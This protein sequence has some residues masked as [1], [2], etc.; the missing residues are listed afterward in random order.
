MAPP[1]ALTRPFNPPPPTPPPP[2][3]PSLLLLLASSWPNLPAISPHLLLFLK[4]KRTSG[5]FGAP[6][7]TVGDENLIERGRENGVKKPNRIAD[8][9]VG[10]ESKRELFPPGRYSQATREK[11]RPCL[12]KSRLFRPGVRPMFGLQQSF[13]FGT[14]RARVFSVII[15]LRYIPMPWNK[16]CPPF[17][18]DSD[19]TSI[20]WRIDC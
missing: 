18:S 2:A 5:N 16:Y 9:P 17:L 19:L 11:R 15:I 10:F 8:R 6:V 1:A 13:S 14:G 7:L 3:P 4:S 20:S 12:Q